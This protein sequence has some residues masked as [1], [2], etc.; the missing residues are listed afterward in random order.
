[1]QKSARIRPVLLF[2]ILGLLF[3]TLPQPAM[4]CE[5]CKHIFFLGYA[6]CRPVAPDEVGSTVCTDQYD[7]YAG[8]S[9]VESGTFCSSIVVGGGGGGTGGTGGSGGSCQT[10]GLCP[11]QCFSCSGGGGRPAV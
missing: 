7:P 4:G 5:V 3:W 1:M 10:S 6:P 11:A 8:F 2:S 9:C